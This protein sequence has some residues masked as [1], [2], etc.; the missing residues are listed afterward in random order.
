[1]P[2]KK[3]RLKIGG[4][5]CSF[6][7]QTIEKAL[8][9]TRG[10]LSVNVSLAHNEALIEYDPDTIRV[11][12][13]KKLLHGLG[14]TVREPSEVQDLEEEDRLLKTELRRLLVGTGF[15]IVATVFMALGWLDYEVP[16]RKWILFFMAT[17]VFFYLGKHIISMSLVALRR[18]IFNQHVLLVFG[19]FG[20]WMAGI[21]G[22]FYS[23]PEFF[24]AC[25]YLTTFH[26]LSGYLSALVRKRSSQAVRKLLSLQPLTATR[27]SDDTE[28]VVS[29][30]ELKKGDIVRVRPGER[31]PVDGIIIEGTTSVD[32]SLITGEPLPVDKTAGDEVVGGA[33]NQTGSILVK[34]TKVGEE[35]FLTT[36]ARY[37]EEARALKPGIILLSDRV[38]SIYVPVVLLTSLGSFFFWLIG[39]RLFGGEGSLLVAT[40]AALSVLVIGYPCALGMAMPLALIRGS[41]LGAEKGVLMRS[42]EAF[43]SF[44]EIKKMVFDKTGT[45]TVGKPEV[46]DIHSLGGLSEEELIKLSASVEKH[47]EHPIAKAIVK[48]AEGMRLYQVESFQAEPG[49]GVE[50]RVNGKRLLVGNLRF[51]KNKGLNTSALAEEI[52]K[53]Q[54]GGKTV[55][56]VARDKSVVGLIGISDRIKEEASSVI[57]TFKSI[58]ISPVMITGDNATS[59][60]AVAKQVGIDEVFAGVLPHEKADRIR[61]LQSQGLRV[62]MV[63]DGIND[64]PALMQA[65]I[66]IAI[67]TGT[68]IAIE[69]ADIIIIG[70]QLSRL[71]TAYEL[72]VKTYRKIKQNLL[73]AFLFNGVGIPIATTGLLH[74]L[75]A[76]TAMVLSTLAIIIN[77]FGLKIGKLMVSAE[78]RLEGVSSLQ[79]HVPGI[80]CQSC[81]R[82][83]EQH[84]LAIK[85]IK[86]VSGDPSEKRLIVYFDSSTASEAKVRDAIRDLG[87]ALEED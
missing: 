20:A 36:V 65:D 61:Q 38:L 55:V 25:I 73:W 17:F 75:M 9:R 53:I 42:G 48:K 34:V 62:A 28:M 31:I 82:Q 76:M 86:G 64:A 59:A 37:V 2:A 14:Y 30:D 74:P 85:G 15:A 52:E 3:V 51:I 54:S 81:I 60:S 79:L 13:I 43:Q 44:R 24:G 67:G 87:Y 29:V 19:A 27:V 77:S 5:M 72:S 18:W 21:L 84:L 7:S 6:C 26:L 50:A 80:H 40:Y 66:G 56:L 49:F 68:D 10:I 70:K 33:I 78:S 22:F 58:G 46:V 39:V 63:G 45:I 57:S 35:S 69:S 41:G 83:I 23:I 32:Q 1:M 8:S 4:M 11:E 16:Y 71:I 12:G 47:S